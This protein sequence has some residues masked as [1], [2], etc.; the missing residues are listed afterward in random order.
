MRSD[1]KGGHHET[2]RADAAS[3]RGVEQG[4]TGQTQDTVEVEGNMGDTDPPPTD[5]KVK[6]LALF[7]W[8]STVSPAAA[9]Y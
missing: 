6:D 3:S 7:N 1:S 9:I 2:E 5:G 8:Q 4:Q